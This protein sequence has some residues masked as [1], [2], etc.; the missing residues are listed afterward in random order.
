M[1]LPSLIATWLGSWPISRLQRY[2]N[3]ADRIVLLSE[4]LATLGDGKLK[5]LAQQVAWKARTGTSLRDLLQ[6]AFALVREASR[7][8]LGMA[9][10]PVQIMGAIAMFEGHIIEMQTG[11]G[12]T[13]T[14]GMPTFLHALTGLGCHVV[15]SNDYLAQR[16]ATLLGPMYQLLGLTSGHIDA[17]SSPGQRQVAYSQDIT[18]GTA[19]EIGFDFLRDRLQQPAGTSPFSHMLDETQP[20]SGIQRG[21]HFV[22]IDEADSILLDDARTPLIIGLELPNDPAT[23]HLY[24]WCRHAVQRL[25]H[26]VDF[27]YE[28]DD[29]RAELTHVGRRNVL[30][31]SK[32]MLLGSVENDRIYEHVEYAITAELGFQRERDYVI[33]KDTVKIVDESTGRI[34]DGRK[35]QQGL[36]QSVEA[37]ERLPITAAT[38]EAARITLQSLFR[39]YTHVAGMTGTAGPARRELKRTYGCPVTSIPPHKPCVRRGLPPRLFA[40]LDAKRKAIVDE[41]TGRHAFGQPILVGTPS[42]RA[43]MAM[44]ALL[45]TRQLPYQILNAYLHEQEAQLMSRA[46]EPGTITIATNMAGR[47]TDIQIADLAR[48]AGGVHV[49]ASEMQSSARIDRQLVGRTGRQGDPGSFQFFLSLEDELLDCLTPDRR[50]QLMRRARVASNGEISSRSWL[51][52][53]RRMQ[54]LLETRHEHL[55]RDLLKQE[56]LRALAYRKMGLDPCL[57][58]MEN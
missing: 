25:Q 27:T 26:G 52:Y 48:Q 23:V 14:A 35:W 36:H 11:E 12:K 46:G 57:E 8:S 13:L 24:R 44:G 10:F 34:M 54:C 17:G 50:S 43:S 19:R 39:H 4:E 3:N 2:R 58:L 7:R 6:E 33:V 1:K 22:L 18:Y 20:R 51:P 55:R 38:G 37:K 28:P 15:T 21:H 5:L 45:Q 56:G 40:T 9:H 29:R 47:G 49:I 42:V 16:D 53:F 31:A 41:I 30:L 32:S